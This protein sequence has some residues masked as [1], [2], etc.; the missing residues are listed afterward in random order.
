MSLEITEAHIEL[1][2]KLNDRQKEAVQ[3]TTNATLVIAGAGSGKTA[4]LTRRV[5]YLIANGITP[6]NIL[7]LT[8][9]NKAAGE[10]NKRV[11]SILDD[12]GVDLP[13]IPLWREDYLQNPLL[14]TFHS[15]GV[16]L[17]R[18]FGDKIDLKKEFTILDSDDQKKIIRQILKEMN[19]SEKT[20][21][22][23]LA[24]YFISQCKQQLLSSDQSRKV[25]KEFLPVFH[26]VYQKY[27]ARLKTNHNVD[28]DDLL[29]LPYQILRDNQDVLEVLRSR[30]T[31]IMIDEFQDTNQAQFEITKLLCPVDLLESDTTR[32]LFVVGDDAQ[33]IYAFRGSRIEIILNFHEDYPS[34]KE[35]VLNQNYRSTQPILDLAERVLSHN[36]KQ[37]KKELFTQNPDK[38]EVSYCLAKNERDEAEYILKQIYQHYVNDQQVDINIPVSKS[39]EITL[40]P[41]DFFDN[42]NMFQPKEKPAY[43]D[44][45]NSS[46][47]ISSMFDVYLDTE[48]FAP[49]SSISSYQPNSWRVPTYDWSKIKKLNECV[50]LYRTH[51]QSRS[52]EET[53]LKY[54]LPYRLVSGTR[55]LDRKEIRD[56][57][58]IL[59]FLANGSDTHSLSRFL[60]LI[61]EGVGPKTLEKI[62]A[63][64]EDFEYPLAPKH[65]SQV[66]ELMSKMQSSWQNHDNLI[67]MTKDLLVTTG[68]FRY[69][70]SEY[71]NK[72]ELENRL[73][74]IGE[75]YS[76]MYPFDEEKDTP[77]K[78]KLN[79]FLTQISLMSQLDD[80][81]EKDK[82]PKLNLMSLHQSKGL[83]FETVFLVGI[84]DG[85]LPHSNS[86]YETNGLEEEVRLAYVGVTRAKKYLHLTSADSRI[87]FGQIKA[88]PVSRIFRPFLDTYAKRRRN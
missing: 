37:K 24:S 81:S 69:L 78:E 56:V 48:E 72:D 32:S 41:E 67:D 79:Q 16:R 74:N 40:E 27:E 54:H 38:I 22:P 49:T 17:L 61:L 42:P 47:P 43:Q 9:T 77:L 70:K 45:S 34:S 52:L 39:N 57:I 1:L 58:S 62:L 44:N 83:E 87:Q 6:G 31:H 73:E 14:C 28:F 11:R 30:W 25:D 5:A 68:Y 15:L 80:D 55:F 75:I 8:F 51:S 26:Q 36:P 23:S 19:V 65:Q 88:N 4:V 20:L 21:Q 53:F 84:E 76:L 50:V 18:E 13:F 29:L 85:L 35:I 3:S 10:M 7:C 64:L 2:Q 60:P 71:P 33:S 82:T 66:L 46:D 86:F 59:R 12:I 63:Y